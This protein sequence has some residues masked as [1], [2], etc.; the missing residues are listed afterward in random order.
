MKR[1]GQSVAALAAVASLVVL[2]ALSATLA[3]LGSAGSPQRLQAP[4]LVYCAAGNRAAIEPAV[5]QYEEEFDVPVRIQYGPSGALESQIELSGKGS[6]FIPAAI[7]PFLNR[8]QR[9]R[10]AREVIPLAE[11]RVVLALHPDVAE[12]PTTWSEFLR[13]A[14]PYGLANPEAAVGRAAQMALAKSQAWDEAKST[15]RVFLPTVTE[16]AE[17]VRQGDE[18]RAALLWDATARQYGLRAVELPEFSYPPAEIGVGVLESAP[19]PTAALRLARY[20]AAPEKGQLFFQRQHYATQPGDPWAETPEVLLYSGTVNRRAINDTIAEFQQREGCRVTTVFEGCGTLVGMMR[21]GSDPDAYLA[22]DVSYVEQVHDR[23]FEPLP[24]SHNRLVMATRRDSPNRIET[25]TDL[26]QPGL[27]IGLCD[28]KLTALGD[29]TV[30][31]L[32]AAG[33]LAG[34]EANQPSTVTT[35]DLLVA[36]LLA[37]DKLDVVIAYEA[38]CIGAADQLKILPIDHPAAL[39]IQPFSIHRGAAYPQLVERL[40]TT[41]QEARS[42][43]RFERAGFTWLAG[44][45]DPQAPQSTQDSDL[46]TGSDPAQDRADP[47]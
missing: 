25:L 3:W 11:F 30:R 26:E 34:V 36:Q 31:M 37:S 17:A 14:I 13:L 4:L 22:C 46:R 27:R 35:G 28:P 10:L 19:N 15:A 40:E 16:L 8:A 18:V 44:P 12:T 45:A 33:V 1:S 5:R 47:S 6:L 32:E 39:A 20:L 24:L 9:K 41:L 29:L 38:N 42:Q 23:F 21:S 7:D 43:R 2:A